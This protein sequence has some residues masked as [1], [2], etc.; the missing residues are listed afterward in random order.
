[1]KNPFKIAAF[2]LVVL[3]ISSCKDENNVDPVI[4]PN[5][6]NT[7]APLLVS[8][9]N[10]AAVREFTPLLDW[11]DF[12]N[13][14]SYRVQIS[15]DANFNGFTVMDSTL[16]TS[17]LNIPSGRLITG[18]YYY[19]RVIAN[20][21]GGGNSNWSSIWR[22]WVILNAPPAPILVLP[23]N[24]ANNVPFMPFFDW[25][26][27]QTAEFYRLQVSSS[28]SFNT[29]LL[30]TNRIT[31]TELQCPPSILITG[32]QY[33]WRVNASNSNGLST[34]D[35]SVPFNF[36]TLSGPIP[37]SIS[38]R[39]TFVDTNFVSLPLYYVAGAYI[40]W[41]PIITGPVEID[42]LNI[43][44]SGNT[45]YADYTIL[46]LQNT[47][48][49]IAVGIAEPGQLTNTIM[50]IY[51][52]DTLH[53]PFSTCPENPTTVTIQNYNGIENINFLT[54]ADTTKRIF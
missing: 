50:G 41:P 4:P 40:S 12:E 32:T 30:D 28:S 46:H 34:S 33:F 20:L 7:N 8:P 22:F 21:N 42:T 11:Q 13:T 23:A 39:I 6:P 26:E 47:A 27:S 2:I 48:Y 16:N 14:A 9:A 54:W 36:T 53:V 31:A 45:Y 35:W 44:H 1:M 5:N 10:G 24:G 52:C 37:Q 3:I 49:K 15:L 29:I 19:W 18:I 25:N 38:G 43:V 17:G 51:G